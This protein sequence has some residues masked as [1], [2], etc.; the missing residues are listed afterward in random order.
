V[1]ALFQGDKESVQKMLKWCST[2]APPSRVD[3]VL[4][5]YIDSR[6]SYNSF[7]LQF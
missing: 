5:E 6:S 3:H 1:E 4:H 7:D 2:G